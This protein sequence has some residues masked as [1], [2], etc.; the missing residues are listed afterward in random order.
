M[1]D[2]P[3]DGEEK[4]EYI[5]PP[6]YIDYDQLNEGYIDRRFSFLPDGQYMTDD[7]LKHHLGR[8]Y[9]PVGGCS[10][11]EVCACAGDIRQ[12][13]SFWLKVCL[14]WRG[15][16]LGF[17]QLCAPHLVSSATTLASCCSPAFFLPGVLLLCFG[18]AS[19][20]FAPTR[21]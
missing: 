10:L 4:D 20:P 21:N 16:V 3:A 5:E 12:C 13:G 7:E 17:L 2:E 11:V 18:R 6:T 1:K 8:W 15:R 14:C 19:V 9:D